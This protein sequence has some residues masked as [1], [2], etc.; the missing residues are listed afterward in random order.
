MFSEELSMIGRQ[1]LSPHFRA[2]RAQWAADA[3]LPD[4]PPQTEIEYTVG[5]DLGQLQDFSALCVVERTAPPDG[6]TT[7]AVRHLHR[8]PLGTAYTT[9]ASD[10]ADTAYRPALGRPSIA[11]DATGVGQAVMEMVGGA[12]RARAGDERG[13]ALC[14]VLITGG[15]AVTRASDLTWHV[16]KVELVSVLQALL[17]SRRLKIAVELP[18]AGIL[19]EELKAFKAKIT[20]AGNETFGAWRERDHDDLV[21]AVALALWLAEN[22]PRGR[23]EIH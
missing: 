8:W 17:S 2:L 19:I 20:V 21:L 10:V 13:V 15:Q 11:A 16:A 12:L 7:Y 6:E 5:L 4:L 14:P 1:P 9:I 3:P 22:A 23:F 18:E